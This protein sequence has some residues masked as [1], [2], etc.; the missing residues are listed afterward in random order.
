MT[1]YFIVNTFDVTYTEIVPVNNGIEIGYFNKWF[2]KLP[3][4]SMVIGYYN[5]NRNKELIKNFEFRKTPNV[6][7]FGDWSDFKVLTGMSYKE[8][9]DKLK[10]T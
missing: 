2:T 7:Y 6:K 3:C 10:I 4:D 8:Y 9:F 5:M 1:R